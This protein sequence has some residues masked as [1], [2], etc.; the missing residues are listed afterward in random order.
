MQDIQNEKRARFAGTLSVS[1]AFLCCCL[2]IAVAPGAV[3]QESAEAESVP[4]DEI[5]VTARKREERLQDVPI[6]ITTFSAADIRAKSLTFLKE[7]G[8]FTPNLTINDHA[9]QGN[10]ASLIYIRGIG[11]EDPAIFWEPGVGM[12]VDGIYNGRLVGLDMD[13]MEVERI[14]V[15]RGPQGTLFG[16]NAIGG[17]INVISKKPDPEDG[18]SGSAEVITG[19]FDRLDGKVNMN[20]PIVP[21]KLAVR[22]GAVTRNRDGYGKRL[23]F[24]T[25]ETIDEVGNKD[26]SSGQMTMNWTP[27]EDVGVLFTLD[28]SRVRELGPV[29]KLIETGQAPFIMLTNIIAD[30]DYGDVFLTNDDFTS[31]ANGSVANELDVLGGGLTIDW[32]IG[33]LY[34]KSITSYRDM[35]TRSAADDDGSFYKILHTEFITDQEQLSQEFQLGGVSSNDRLNWLAGFFYYEE[36]AYTRATPDGFEFAAMIL[37]VDFLSFVA[38]EQVETQ[39]YAVFG[40]GTYSFNDQLSTTIGLR[41]T[42]DDKEVFRQRN[43]LATGRT[44]IPPGRQDDTWDDVSGRVGLEYRWSDDVMTYFSIARGY[45]AGG[46]NARSVSSA[47]FVPFDPETVLTYEVGLKSG[48]QDNRLRFN[49]T[50]FF[51]DYNDI[52]FLVQRNDPVTLEN[53]T[54]VDNAA[55]A[56]IKGFELELVATPVSGFNLSAGLGYTDAK[57]TEVEPGSSVSEDTNFINTPEWSGVFSAQYTLPLVNQSELSGRIDY[58]YQSKTYYDIENSPLIAQDGY[59]LLRARIDLESSDGKWVASVFGTNLTDERYITAGIDRA[60]VLGFAVVQYARPR[61][62]GVSFR[63]NF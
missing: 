62:W 3:A 47:E 57:Y 6:S 60:A 16:R 40:Q 31:Y 7:V 38:I 8:Q 24:L 12:Y 34:F 21:G 56:E 53:L 37:G 32:D 19:S 45:K 17:A 1:F 42:D 5:T 15:L 2:L 4:F 49:G 52:Q 36:D 58:T 43:A 30:P 50:L 14:E 28:T 11:Q 48:S 35:D 18:F 10:T 51:N 27:N 25:G 54:F 46:I 59:G 61:E 41:Y 13:L 39:S 20:V 33:E 55:A 9:Q 23:D 63:Y 22:V 29:R 26:S 44:L